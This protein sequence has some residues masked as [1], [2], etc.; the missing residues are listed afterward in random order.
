MVMSIQKQ[1]VKQ[2]TANAHNQCPCLSETAKDLQNTKKNLL[3]LFS[4]HIETVPQSAD[5][6]GAELDVDPMTAGAVALYAQ[7]AGPFER[8]AVVAGHTIRATD[9]DWAFGNGPVLEGTSLQIVGF[10]LGVTDDPPR[11]PH[12]PS[13]PAEPAATPE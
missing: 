3:R 5:T 11:P 4:N 7:G 8:R 2:W 6:L 10:L 1:Q 9:A 12:Q 13:S